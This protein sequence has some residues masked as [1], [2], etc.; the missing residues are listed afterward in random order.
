MWPGQ[1]MSLKVEEVLYEGRSKF[2]VCARIGAPTCRERRAL[3][4]SARRARRR[5]ACATTRAPALAAAPRARRTSLSSNLQRTV[6]C[7]SWMA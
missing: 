4:R 6:A 1:K 7:S 3:L 5:A 2:Q